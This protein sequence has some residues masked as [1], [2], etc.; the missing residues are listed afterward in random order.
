[1]LNHGGAETQI[2]SIL[3]QRAFLR[4]SA[5]AVDHYFFRDYQR[6]AGFKKRAHGVML[7]VNAEEEKM[8][9]QTQRRR[10]K[11]N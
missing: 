9:N 10:G 11:T 2:K 5:S 1:M 6:S 4:V 7:W 3:F 8:L